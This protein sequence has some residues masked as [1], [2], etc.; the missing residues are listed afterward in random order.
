MFEKEH[1]MYGL[2]KCAGCN[3]RCIEPDEGETPD[4]DGYAKRR[5]ADCTVNDGC[6]C[7]T[8]DTFMTIVA[9][10]ENAV[11]DD[12]ETTCV[13][14]RPVVITVKATTHEAAIEAASDLLQAHFGA[15]VEQLYAED[16]ERDWWF[17]LNETD[18]LLRVSA[19]FK[20]DPPLINDGDF[21]NA[22]R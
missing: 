12:G 10:W 19:V 11:G 18:P 15:S 20:G 2:L 14:L 13:D 22:L 7:G 8:Q 9:D 6:F 21:F 4:E 17:G 1:V 16:I 5:C 3:D